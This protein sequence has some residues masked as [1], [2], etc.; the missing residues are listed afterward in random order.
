MK[1]NLIPERLT[2]QRNRLNITKMAAAKKMNISQGAYVRYELGTRTPTYPTVVA[3][4]QVL[5]TSAEYLTGQTDNPDPITV[6]ISCHDEPQLFELLLDY[7]RLDDTR[8]D[9]LIKYWK[10]LSSDK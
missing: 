4:A 3:M 2:Q 9:R 10:K 1:S 8:K 6:T 7:H 5:K